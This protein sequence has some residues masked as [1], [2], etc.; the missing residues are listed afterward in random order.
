[1]TMIAVGSHNPAKIAAVKQVAD[2]LWPTNLQVI[3]LGVPSG[4]ADMPLNDAECRQ[5]AINR[6][7]AARALLNSDFGI[8][9]E[10]GVDGS[11][12]L[13]WL[14]GWVAVVDRQGRVGLGGTARLRL[15]DA[16]ARQ[17]LAGE[18]LGPVID[19]L[20]GEENVRQ[21]G[22]AVGVLTAGLV[23]RREQFGMA[24]AYALAPFVNAAL[25]DG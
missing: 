12:D 25:Y 11:A 7:T 15:P 24:V 10:G 6:A 9:L 8:G 22:G 20:V 19:R 21:R 17:V 5:G 4:V 13:L 18:E 16:I 1:M 2:T 14:T 23:S 3:G